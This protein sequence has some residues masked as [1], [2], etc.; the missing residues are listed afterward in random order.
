MDAFRY[1]A[2]KSLGYYQTTLRV[3]SRIELTSRRGKRLENGAPALTSSSASVSRRS[4]RGIAFFAN[5]KYSRWR[6]TPMLRTHEGHRNQEGLGGTSLRSS[7]TTPNPAI[8]QQPA[9]AALALTLSGHRP[10]VGRE[11]GPRLPLGELRAAPSPRSPYFFRSFMRLSRVN[12]PESRRAPSTSGLNF[13]M[14]RARPSLMASAWPVI[15]PPSTR[16]TTSTCSAL[17]GLHQ[18]GQHGV[19][20]ARCGRTPRR[21]GY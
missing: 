15:P 9:L 14:A 12:K 17:A 10:K 1:P 6:S 20:A 16:T 2:M 18:R 4:N 13:F 7:H 21:G 11:R 19:A 8:R 3:E 5:S